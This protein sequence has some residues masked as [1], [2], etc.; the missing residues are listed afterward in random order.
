MSAQ[1]RSIS[2]T[3]IPL[4]TF[5]S[6]GPG[7]QHAAGTSWWTTSGFKSRHPGGANFCM[8]D[9]SVHFIT[10]TIDYRLYNELGSRAGGEV[11]SLP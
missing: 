4:N 9:G 5:E 11:A 3:T 10:E 8:G 7:G 1:R 6:D 2:P